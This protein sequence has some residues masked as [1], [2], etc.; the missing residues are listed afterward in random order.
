MWPAETDEK[1]LQ[2]KT[3]KQNSKAFSSR[4]ATLCNGHES[5]LYRS[6]GEGICNIS[7]PNC[8]TRSLFKIFPQN[9][10]FSQNM[11]TQIRSYQLARINKPRT[12]TAGLQ[13]LLDLFEINAV[14]HCSRVNKK[15][16]CE[17]DETRGIKIVDFIRDCDKRRRLSGRW[18]KKDDE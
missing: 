18:W 16:L 9:S 1:Q 2:T 13:L 15:L 17:F 6:I 14:N 4:P 5:Y 12:K 11:K 8:F 3:N 7:T 10:S